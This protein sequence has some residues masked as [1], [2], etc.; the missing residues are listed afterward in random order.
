MAR[1]E[2]K[3]RAFREPIHPDAPGFDP[4]QHKDLITELNTEILPSWVTD[5]VGGPTSTPDT[6]QLR[7]NVSGVLEYWNG[8][9]WKLVGGGGGSGSSAPD[10]ERLPSAELAHVYDLARVRA[11][12]NGWEFV[13]SPIGQPVTPQ[14]TN[15]VLGTDQEGNWVMRRVS[16]PAR[17]RVDLARSTVPALSKQTRSAQFGEYV[18]G[19]EVSVDTSSTGDVVV[20]I[21]ADAAK[22]DKVYDGLFTHTARSDVA[23]AWFFI[24]EDAEGTAYIEVENLSGGPWPIGVTVRGVQ[25]S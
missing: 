20:R 21:Y 11:D 6:H 13:S 17:R 8:S 10:A 2:I 24:S 3:P 12:G 9:A 1:R 5:V 23:Q 15:K 19:L 16:A 18:Y 7:L 4:A 14:D 22:T 25:F